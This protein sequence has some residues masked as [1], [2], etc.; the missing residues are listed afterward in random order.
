MKINVK[1][2]SFIKDAAGTGKE[3]LE[4]NEGTTL[5]G[6]IDFLISK[7]GEKFKE[8]IL[9]EGRL[10]PHI[11]I[12]CSEKLINENYLSLLMEDGDEILIFPPVAGG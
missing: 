4:I 9:K 6:L 11:K 2:Y 7:Y 10:N 8:I 5:A 1:F 12:F 3:S